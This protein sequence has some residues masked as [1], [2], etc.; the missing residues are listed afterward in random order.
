MSTSKRSWVRLVWYGMVCV[1]L[2]SLLICEIGREAI[3]G[4]EAWKDSGLGDSLY[5]T[6]TRLIGGVLGIV[7]ILY[8][9]YGNILKLHVRTLGQSILLTLPCWIIAI[10]NFPWIPF[11]MEKAAVTSSAGMIFLYA[12]Q[13]FAVGLFEETAFRGC[14]FM[15]ILQKRRESVL[16]IFWSIVLSSAVFGAIHMVNLLA[17]ASP[18]SVILQIGYSFLIGGM[19]SVVLM[20]T[21][22]IWHC[23]LLHAVYNFCGGVIPTLGEGKIWD[24]PTV[25]LTVVLSLLV[26]AY[27]IRLLVLMKPQET[28][29]LFSREGEKSEQGDNL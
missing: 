12:L 3:F 20:K 24:M 15:L 29:K 17:G 5:A 23:V 25:V 6:V 4:R 10:N 2:L 27:V 19:C 22:S 28:D 26:T 9:N 21:G 7:L 18:L 8:C 13:C 14:I 1:L 16:Q 11:C